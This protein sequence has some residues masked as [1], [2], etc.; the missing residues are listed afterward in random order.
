M[1][2]LL[3]LLKDIQKD[4][5]QLFNCLQ[6]EKQALD[7]NQLDKLNDIAAQKQAL[8]THLSELDKQ[9][10]ANSPTENFNQF[11]AETRDNVLIKQWK[12]TRE[13]IANCQKQN[14]VNGRILNKRT[15]INKDILSLLTGRELPSETTYD[16]QGSQSNQSS[17]LNGIKA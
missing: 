5:Q 13:S 6:Q 12:L 4:S 2:Y 10:I 17:I 7:D 9:R 14:E 8:I 11:I 15:L 3:S 16:A 1:S